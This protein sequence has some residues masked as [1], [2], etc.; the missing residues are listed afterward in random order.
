MNC[1][2]CN[3]ELEEGLSLCPNCG[4]KITDRKR[5]HKKTLI[6][7]CTVIGVALLLGLAVFFLCSPKS[8]YSPG[9]IRKVPL[10]QSNLYVTPALE[11]ITIFSPAATPT[12]IAEYTTVPSRP[13]P[14]IFYG[15][16]K[17]VYYVSGETMKPTIIT[18][19]PYSWSNL[20]VMKISEDGSTLLYTEDTDPSREYYSANLIYSDLTAENIRHIKLDSEVNNFTMNRDGSLIFYLKNQELYI[21]DLIES[22]KLA[23]KVNEFY[24]NRKGDRILYRTSDLKLYL[25]TEEGEIR[26]LDSDA[27]LMFVSEDLKLIYYYKKD[28]LYLLKDCRDLFLID[29]GLRAVTEAIVSIY[30]DGSVYYLKPRRLT[31]ADF[32]MENELAQDAGLWEALKSSDDSVPEIYSLYYYSGGVSTLISDLCMKVWRYSEESALS[33]HY[34]GSDQPILAFQQL[35]PDR[36]KLTKAEDYEMLQSLISNSDP[37]YVGQYIC[38]GPKVLGK[39][40]DGEIYYPIYDLDKQ[41]IFYQRNYYE[42]SNRGD[43]YSVAFDGSFV[44]EGELYE[45][46]VIMYDPASFAIGPYVVYLKN[47]DNK[48][49]DYILFVDHKEIDRKVIGWIHKIKNSDA[50]IYLSNFNDHNGRG[51]YSETLNL[52]KDGKAIKISENVTSF[53]AFDEETIVYATEDDSK[54][55]QLYLYDGS[56][57]RVLIDTYNAASSFESDLLPPLENSYSG[58]HRKTFE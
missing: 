47:G 57:T 56:D 3:V 32:A 39:F 36:L 45:E 52:Y 10:D 24:I 29:S 19:Y 46:K 16:D 40:A 53:Y 26:E 17:R 9:T 5:K 55:K 23:D 22:R 4:M 18:T 13:L 8:D 37:S 51:I 27:Y 2:H 35:K 31:A 14:N 15:K 28:S 12:P 58:Y 6:L 11:T 20:F 38:K 21:Y 1:M 44:G 34:R 43:L 48:A 33:Y 54:M 49:E 50:F 7:C 30:E 42:H 25:C 41:K